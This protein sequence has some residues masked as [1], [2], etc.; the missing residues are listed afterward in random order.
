MYFL[1]DAAAL[2]SF[3]FA[4][5]ILSI[6]PG[7]DMMLFL[8]RTVSYGRLAG[9]AAMFGATTGILIHT[10]AVAIGLSALIAASPEAFAVLK[11]AGAGYLIYL[12][13]Q[14]V[15]HGSTFAMREGGKPQTLFRHWLTGLTINLLN[16]K[17]ILFFVTF[18]P[19]FVAASDPHA[20]SKLAF[21]GV[22]FIAIGCPVSAVFILMASKVVA[23]LRRKPKVMRAL[24]WIFA[25][26]FSAFAVNL[27]LARA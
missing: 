23:V 4:A 17:I 9:F 7:P 8:G 19:Q 2:A 16:P 20:G 26:V 12:A 15:R 25:S 18:L 14:A 5:L 6:T 24:D 11:I 1:P 13:V 27:M 22:L 10:T 3:A 21:L